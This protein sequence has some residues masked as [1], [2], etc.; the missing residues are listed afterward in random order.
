MSAV[1]S[2]PLPLVNTTLPNIEPP[3]PDDLINEIPKSPTRNDAHELWTDESSMGSND[4]DSIFDSDAEAEEV[5]VR[6]DEAE[7]EESIGEPVKKS[8][9]KRESSGENFDVPLR[10]LKN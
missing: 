9:R 1:N 2:V 6:F 7:F 3:I 8:S 5:E 10:K 4:E